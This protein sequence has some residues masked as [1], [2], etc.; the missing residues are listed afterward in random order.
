MQCRVENATWRISESSQ[1]EGPF[2]AVAFCVLYWLIRSLS[3]AKQC[4]EGP[5]IVID[6]KPKRQFLASKKL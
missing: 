5:F 6:V 2:S 4:A 1:I 3:Q